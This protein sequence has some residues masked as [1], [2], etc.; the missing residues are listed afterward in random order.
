MAEK[1]SEY[2]DSPVVPTTYPNGQ[3][4]D[5]SAPGANDGTL[6]RN[7]H[8]QDMWNVF[9]RL[10]DDSGLA[11]DTNPDTQ[12][13]SQFYDALSSMGPSVGTVEQSF[14]T[15]VQFL[16]QPGR[17]GGTWVRCDGQSAVGSKYETI[18]G[19]SVVPNLTGRFLRDSTGSDAGVK[20][21]Q[22]N[23]MG[24]HNHTSP[25]H[26]H[27]IAHTHQWSAV[28]A[29]TH[30]AYSYNDSNDSRISYTAGTAG[31]DQYTSSTSVQD[32]DTV[33]VTVT[34]GDATAANQEYYTT[35][36]LSPPTGGD[37]SSAA[38]GS[39]APANTGPIT[40]GSTETRP[41]SIIVNTFIK[42]N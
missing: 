16:A 8:I 32:F 40:T 22:A 11:F 13:A 39:T 18:T 30:S 3:L 7:V 23:Q 20:T 35:G 33:A 38:T 10:M 17:T 24:T 5:E 26:T 25:S 2:V 37:G 6:V 42:I 36:V 12:P 14:L 21:T 28:A 19:L 34:R 27:N 41:D 1:L 29:N 31:I 15:E 9:S 4:V